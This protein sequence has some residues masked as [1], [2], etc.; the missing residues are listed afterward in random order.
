MA[1]FQFKGFNSVF[2][3]LNKD[4]KSHR[5]RS[6]RA[7]AQRP[8]L[9]QA[10]A[11]RVGSGRRPRGR[12]AG[13]SSPGPVGVWKEPS[14]NS[15]QRGEGAARSS[16]CGNFARREA[17]R[18]AETRERLG[19]GHPTTRILTTTLVVTQH[20]L[21]EK[22]GKEGD[23]LLYGATATEIT[24][25]TE[26][27]NK[28]RSTLAK[29]QP[30]LCKSD[31][32]HGATRCALLDSEPHFQG[33]GLAP[34]EEALFSNHKET[35]EELKKAEEEL[36]RVNKE[37]E[38]LK[39]KLEAL[40]AAGAESVKHGS[41]KLQEDFNKRSED[42]KKRQEGT[43][44]IMKARKLEQE[45]KL[46]ESTDNLSR[47]NVQLHEKYNRIEELE[48][49]VQRMEEERKT[50]NEKKRSL[51]EKLHQ[52]MS[53]A[54]NTKSCV[55]VQ[56]EI[57]TLQEQISHL[58]HVIHSQH[59]NLHS[60]IHQIEEL[61]NELKYQDERIELLKEKIEI[62][63][64]KNKELQYKVDFYSGQSKTKVSKAVSAKMDQTSP[65]TRLRK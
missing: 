56:T 37:N 65:Y 34:N 45:Q 30:L 55:R 46:K 6:G 43:I 39:I 23:F 44:H 26:Y 1:E 5:N 21:A 47:L 20:I 42:L 52:M 57:S 50:L 41:Q 36:S 59:Q 49:R 48:K 40:R 16:G 33:P 22:R 8:A 31:S 24:E 60:L 38:R 29:V 10:A 9:R 63:Q 7:K 4:F 3:A 14:R 19:R 54:E 12:A 2:S 13:R 11:L 27:I 17:G 35:V 61:N 53:K 18:Q 25:E 62:L 32:D 28:I 15:R 64:A 58:D 51:K